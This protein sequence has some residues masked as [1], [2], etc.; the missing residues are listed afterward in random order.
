MAQAKI[1]NIA[2][3]GCSSAGKSTIVRLLAEQSG[4]VIVSLDAKNADG[5][6]LVSVTPVNPKEFMEGDPIREKMM[7]EAKEANKHKKPFFIDD[8]FVDIIQYL[9]KRTTRIVLLI[10]TMARIIKNVKAR[11][12]KAVTAGQERFAANVLAQLI[13]FLVPSVKLT[14]AQEKQAIWICARDIYTAVELDKM[15]YDQRDWDRWEAVL[16]S[17]LHKFGFGIDDLKS[18]V[19]LTKYK[20]FLP[21]N[22]GQHFTV[23]ADEQNPQELIKIILSN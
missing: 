14:K 20:A 1:P 23:I 15:F 19:K 12:L 17:S 10:P 9:N 3:I 8:A 22:I 21:K 7:Q 2:I 13:D 4:G 16:L 18:K 6:S 5:R 11:N